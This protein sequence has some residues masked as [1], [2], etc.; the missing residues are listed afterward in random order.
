M[1]EDSCSSPAQNFYSFIA[2][3]VIPLI[4][5]LEVKINRINSGTIPIESAVIFAAKSLRY[6][7]FKLI[8]PIGTVYVSDL[9][10]TINGTKNEFQFV[11]KFINP[12]VAIA[13]LMHGTA[14]EKRILGSLA[15]SI[16]ALSIS[17]F[18]KLLPI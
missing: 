9:F 11:T 13:G 10:N 15:P 17:S 16:L 12:N 1:A 4:N 8:M 6:A 18:G 7:E 5:V 3:I 2:P 14:T